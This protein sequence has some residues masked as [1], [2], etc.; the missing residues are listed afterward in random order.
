MNKKTYITLFLT[1]LL[2]S[3]KAQNS[4]KDILVNMNDGLKDVSYVSNE[5]F[6][7]VGEG[8]KILKSKNSGKNWEELN[9]GIQTGLLKIQFPSENTG[10]ILG[11]SNILLKTEDSGNNWFPIN[12]SSF[13]G[14]YLTGFYFYN[15]DF[16]L[17][18]GRAGSMYRTKDGG[19]N[20]KKI[21]F[22]TMY[23]ISTICFLNDSVGYLFEGSGK[24]WKTNDSGDTWQ[25]VNMSNVGTNLYFKEMEFVDDN[26]GYLLGTNGYI[27][28]TSDGGNT[29]QKVN[30]EV[31]NYC[32]SMSFIN[33]DT[34]Y[35]AGGDYFAKLYKTTDGGVTW[36]SMIDT[37][38]GIIY[39]IAINKSG[40]KGVAV[41]PRTNSYPQNGRISLYLDSSDNKWK[42]S[43]TLSGYDDFWS[44]SFADDT[45]G[46]ITGGSNYSNG[47]VYK[48][49]N[50]G[51]SWK[52]LSFSPSYK[53]QYSYLINKDTV[54]ISSDK[55]YKTTDGGETWS[56]ICPYSGKLYFNKT[57][58]YILTYSGLYRTQDGGKNWI[59]LNIDGA[60]L[61]QDIT[62]KNDSIGYA[63]GYS[64]VFQSTDSG[65]TWVRDT[66][67]PNNF[68][69]SVYFYNQSIGYIGGMKG[70][71][72]KTIN[73]GE[74]WDS[75]ATGIQQIQ[76]VSINDIK[77][78]NDS[79]GVLLT[80]NEGSLCGVYLTHNGG[81]SW[82]FLR[83][84][85]QNIYK[86]TLTNK[87][88]VFFVG[89][90]ATF[91]K[92]SNNI[93]P[94][95]SGYINGPVKVQKNTQFIYTIQKQTDLN[96]KWT[97]SGCQIIRS[98]NDTVIVSFPFAGKCTLTVTPS[99]SCNWGLPRDIE[100]TVN[101]TLQSNVQNQHITEV[102]INPNPFKDNLKISLSENSDYIKLVICDLSGK[103][104]RE[105][106]YRNHFGSEINLNLPELKDGIY[107]L[108]IIQNNLISSIKLVKY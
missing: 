6:I 72:Y 12:T 54:F 21:N 9:S 50:G 90:G 30:S 108:R 99:N 74:T 52:K 73:G 25:G 59:N 44:L 61:L 48:T 78:K 15:P 18:F 11:S 64:G 22:T 55:I 49:F 66:K 60:P 75:I 79:D 83:Q 10:Y 5:T 43:T 107:I 63:V 26:T 95:Q 89:D 3:L 33:K 34:G 14:N 51:L 76:Y 65:R 82:Q 28:K 98:S 56:D 69:K 77:F 96:Y 97:S 104:V 27:I 71:L 87:K 80:N 24:L 106:E 94:M 1:L 36:Q 103:I 93:Q 68:Y 53:I 4:C 57:N 19:R 17:L 81:K 40:D 37:S 62:F 70:V 42:N 84:I 67:L 8:G 86:L 20:W 32:Y 47:T 102:N 92:I 88:D 45:I 2:I 31:K 35:I 23:E 105:F 85:T 46:Y 13:S 58:G 29:W 91:M 101:D 7:A 100:I 39:G 41:G 38:N 16:G